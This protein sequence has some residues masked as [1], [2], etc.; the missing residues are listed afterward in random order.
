ML[1]FKYFFF[2]CFCSLPCTSAWFDITN[3]ILIVSVHWYHPT[4]SQKNFNTF[5]QLLKHIFNK[6]IFNIYLTFD[7]KGQSSDFLRIHCTIFS[8]ICQTRGKWWKKKE[9]KIQGKNLRIYCFV[10]H[11]TYVTQKTFKCFNKIILEI[12]KIL[13][14]KRLVL[15]ILIHFF[16]FRRM[17]QLINKTQVLT[18]RQ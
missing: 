15:Y 18:D 7:G 13:V 9:N 4:K 2:L 10:W 16:Y 12:L 1:L 3:R 14:N 6:Y 17:R 5:V 11:G 8:K